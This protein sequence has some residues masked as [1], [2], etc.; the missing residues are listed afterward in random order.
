MVAVEIVTIRLFAV[1]ADAAAILLLFFA[2]S[3]IHLLAMYRI[4]GLQVSTGI[5]CIWSQHFFI[6]FFEWWVILL[7]VID[8]WIWYFAS[9]CVIEYWL[10]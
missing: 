10:A 9:V 6:V 2:I 8:M 4:N 1:A 3:S 5:K 7:F